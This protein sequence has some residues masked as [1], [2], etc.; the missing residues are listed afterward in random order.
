[1]YFEKEVILP[2]GEKLY[3][4]NARETDAE[5]LLSVFKETH[6]ESD[7][8]LTYPEENCFTVMDETEF[9]RGKRVSPNEIELLGFIDGELAGSAG[10]EQIGGREK[11]RHRADFGISILKKFWGKGIG[12][13]LLLASVECAKKAGYEQVELQMVSENM[14]AKKLYESVG[15]TEFGRNPKGFKTRNGK[16]QELI[17]MRYD[18]CE[19]G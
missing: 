4:R 11:I 19:K 14:R 13:A 16:Y 12:R 1:M 6:A 7:F 8:L 2:C 17:L 9:L 5:A 15:F 18:F 3:I 10:I